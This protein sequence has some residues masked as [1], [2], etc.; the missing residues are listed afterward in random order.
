M[1]AIHNGAFGLTN[2]IVKQLPKISSP[3]PFDRIDPLKLG[4][5]RAIY[6][7]LNAVLIRF[8]FLNNLLLMV[9]L[10]SLIFFADDV[11]KRIEEFMQYLFEGN[12]TNSISDPPLLKCDMDCKTLSSKLTNVL[13]TVNN[14]PQFLELSSNHDSS[15]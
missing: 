4:N 9:F 15:L 12:V 11:Q 13:C 8:A 1:N 2:Q 3:P 6:F 7:N 5:F 14:L 10:I